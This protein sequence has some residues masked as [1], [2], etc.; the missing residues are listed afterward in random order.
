MKT[1]FAHS[2]FIPFILGPRA[3]L[4][5]RARTQTSRLHP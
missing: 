4:L 1:V 2:I 3:S 5:V